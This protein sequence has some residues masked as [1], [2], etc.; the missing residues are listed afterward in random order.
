MARQELSEA[1]HRAVQLRSRAEICSWC[2]IVAIKRQESC[3]EEDPPPEDISQLA[4]S[5][6]IDPSPRSR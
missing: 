5:I 1:L 3:A 4:K 6:N 2:A